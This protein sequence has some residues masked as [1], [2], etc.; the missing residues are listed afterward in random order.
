MGRWLALIP[1]DADAPTKSKGQNSSNMRISGGLYLPWHRIVVKHM[2]SNS[3]VTYQSP[4]CSDNSATDWSAAAYST[5]VIPAYIQL[6]SI[7]GRH[8]LICHGICANMHTSL[9]SI[10]STDFV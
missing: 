9:K 2:D 4:L 8:S 10:L 6:A 7:L 3:G 1:E 5:A